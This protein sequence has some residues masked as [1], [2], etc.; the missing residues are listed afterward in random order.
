MGCH[1]TESFDPKPC[2][3]SCA[4]FFVYSAPQTGKLF[5]YLAACVTPTAS[6]EVL[7]SH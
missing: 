7:V 5:R 6:V 4:A 2:K 1:I 3:T